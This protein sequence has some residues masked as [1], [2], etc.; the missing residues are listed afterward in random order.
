MAKKLYLLRHAK[1]GH[2][3][4][5]DDH[6]RPLNQK[7]KEDAE[8]MGHYIQHIGIPDVILCSTAKRTQRTTQLLIRAFDEEPAIY[9][10]RQLYLATPGEML[11]AIHSMDGAGTILVV[12]H[13]PGIHQLSVLLTGHAKDERYYNSMRLKFP[14]CAL[15]V[16][17]ANIASWKDLEPGSCTLEAF[18]TPKEV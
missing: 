4:H 17:S 1:S 2:P 14:T 5:V 10:Q 8:T 7:G 18:I 6:G 15:S 9:Y 12:A 3:P 13:N 11:K 16:F